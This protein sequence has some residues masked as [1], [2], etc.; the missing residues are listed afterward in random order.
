MK[1]GKRNV[2]GW[3]IPLKTIVYFE[4]FILLFLGQ[5]I[6]D[7]SKSGYQIRKPQR[8]NKRDI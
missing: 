7:N 2:H 8:A 6:R 1:D 3:D 5:N 4:P